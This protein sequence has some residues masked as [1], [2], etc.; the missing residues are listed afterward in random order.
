MRLKILISFLIL[1][2]FLLLVFVARK[3]F[4]LKSQGKVAS[5]STQESQIKGMILP[6]H[7]LAKELFI[8][9]LTKLQKTHSPSLFVIFG[10]N[11]YYYD[12]PDLI[13]ALSVYDYPIDKELLRSFLKEFPSVLVNAKIIEQEHSITVPVLYLRN[14]FP[15]A[16]IIPFIVSSKFRLFNIEEYAKYFA[17]F[18][19]KDT[20]YIA[21]VD[22]SHGTDF[23]EAMAKNEESIK[24]ISEF[25]YQALYRFKDDHL[26]SSVAVALLLKTMQTLN[27]TTWETWANSH[28][29]FFT[30][31]FASQGTSYVVGVFR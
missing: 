8:T 16:K 29:A 27:S 23:Q 4:Y 3:D 7:D 28:S 12:S 26:D 19:P 21:A 18:F 25:D 13:T 31:D 24:V 22:F 10:T 6:H 17:D 20:V 2:V 14:Y 5:L 15:D 11:H 1:I 30:S 9:S